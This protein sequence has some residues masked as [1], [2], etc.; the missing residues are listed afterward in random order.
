MFCYKKL[1]EIK[2]RYC[3]TKKQVPYFGN[4]FFCR[5]KK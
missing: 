2:N 4:P 1:N 5:Y 3:Y